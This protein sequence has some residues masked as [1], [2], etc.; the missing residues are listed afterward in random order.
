MAI[1]LMSRVMLSADNLLYKDS[2]HQR[3][4]C[5]VKLVQAQVSIV[6]GQDSFVATQKYL[7]T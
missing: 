7:L 1:I 4:L 3:N 2:I 6:L 5:K